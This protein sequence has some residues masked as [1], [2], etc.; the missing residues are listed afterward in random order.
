MSSA[1]DLKYF[2][3]IAQPPSHGYLKPG[4]ICHIHKTLYEAKKKRNETVLP[5]TFIG[6]TYERD[7]KADLLRPLLRV[8]A[9]L[10]LALE[11][12]AERIMALAKKALMTSLTLTKGSQVFVEFKNEW[13]TGVI[14]YI[15]RITPC[16]LDP[17]AGVFFGV[18]LQV[19]SLHACV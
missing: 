1:D 2:I 16:T 8:E 13:L 19:S 9:E 14:Q 5:V 15:G 12:Y 3:L 10:L 6:D 18:E 17:I 4:Q 11:D 7:L